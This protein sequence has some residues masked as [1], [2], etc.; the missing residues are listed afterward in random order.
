MSIIL[1]N[2]ENSNIFHDQNLSQEIIQT[3]KGILGV[4]E[5]TQNSDTTFDNDI[6]EYLYRES[7][8]V[9]FEKSLFVQMYLK[10]FKSNSKGETINWSNNL[11]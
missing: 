8:F 5:E 6:V 4:F 7:S 9:S 11:F 1:D 2:D 10:S 3:A